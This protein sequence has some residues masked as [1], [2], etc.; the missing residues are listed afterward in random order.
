M[1]Q[2]Y[3][4]TFALPVLNDTIRIFRLDRS[5]VHLAIAVHDTWFEITAHLR[6]GKLTF[7]IEKTGDTT[8]AGFGDFTFSTLRIEPDDAPAFEKWLE[9]NTVNPLAVLEQ[10]TSDGFKISVTYVIDQNSFCVTVVGT[11]ETKRHDKCGMS[12]WSDDLA[13]ALGMTWYKHYILCD[14]S[15]WP[16]KG[17]GKRWG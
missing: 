2:V 7:R 16:T 10:F 4:P 9:G 15:E 11:K 8:M 1:Q 6:R 17:H 12:S 13:E 5:N 14:G 3:L